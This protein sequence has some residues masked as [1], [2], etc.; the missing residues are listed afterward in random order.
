VTYD[1][2]DGGR[3]IAGEEHADRVVR[4]AGSLGTTELLLRCRDEHRTLTGLSRRLGEGWS[5]NANV[6]TPD[7]YPSHQDVQQSIGPTISGGLDFMDGS[8]GG[9]RFYIEDDGFPNLLLNAVDAKVRAGHF[10]LLGLA[11]RAHLRRGTRELN[12]LGNVMMWLG[13]GVDAADGRLYLGRRWWMPWKKDLQLAWDVA[14]SKPVIDAI[15]QAHGRLSRANGGSLRIPLYWTLLR[16][17]VTVHPLGG[18][19]MGRDAGE[20]VVDHRGEVFGHPNLFVADGSVLP[21]P[22]GR[23]P[24]MTIAA[25]AERSARLMADG[26]R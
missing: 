17:L 6:L 21:R 16:G 19:R 5:A 8:A 25:L 14:R 18:C 24:S 1:R 15:L 2:I 23:N 4:A 22:V 7:H 3:L 11:L 9:H 20:G 26:G 13:E 10:S 12:P